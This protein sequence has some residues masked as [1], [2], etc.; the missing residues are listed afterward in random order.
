MKTRRAKRVRSD[1]SYVCM[2]ACCVALVGMCLV[3]AGSFMFQPL[4]A[5]DNEVAIHTI[6]PYFIKVLGTSRATIPLYPSRPSCLS[7]VGYTAWA[8]WLGG[9]IDTL[10]P[11]KNATEI[12]CKTNPYFKTLGSKG[13]NTILYNRFANIITILIWL[14]LSTN[15]V[16]NKLTH[17][18]KPLAMQ[19]IH[20]H[21]GPE[22]EN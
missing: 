5:W 3:E 17:Y 20:P 4:K 16:G 22:H 6:N 1:T 8:W 11:L 15:K 14:S 7:C 19:G 21:P 18:P 12:G 10:N 9:L 2:I 13:A